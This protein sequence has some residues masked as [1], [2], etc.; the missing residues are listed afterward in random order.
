MQIWRRQT[1]PKSFQLHRKRRGGA[2]VVQKGAPA[3]DAKKDEREFN[4]YPYRAV[5]L[6]CGCRSPTVGSK[7]FDCSLLSITYSA[8]LP[9]RSSRKSVSVVIADKL[10]HRVS[11]TS[12]AVLANLKT[13]TTESS[14]AHVCFL[15]PIFFTSHPAQINGYL[16]LERSVQD[17]PNSE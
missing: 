8:S 6:S 13:Y 1:T 10:V 3:V 9:R 16:Q 5:G 15:K 11:R 17:P 14:K 4:G 7:L 12:R 2:P